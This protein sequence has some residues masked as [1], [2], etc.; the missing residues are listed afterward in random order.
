MLNSSSLNVIQ[1][2]DNTPHATHE[3]T[4]KKT[5]KALERKPLTKNRNRDTMPTPLDQ[6]GFNCLLK[7]CNACHY[8]L[9]K[10]DYFG[11]H[12]AK[13][14]T[15]E[16]SR[17]KT[18]VKA[19]IFIVN[20]SD[21]D[22]FWVGW[23]K[24]PIQ[25]LLERGW[26]PNSNPPNAEVEPEKIGEAVL[27]MPDH[28]WLL[29]NFE[30]AGHYGYGGIAE[31]LCC[32]PGC[33]KECDLRV[34]SHCH[35]SRYCSVEHQGLHWRLHK[36]AAA[37]DDD[38]DGDDDAEESVI[39]IS[40]PVKPAQTLDISIPVRE[41]ME[42]LQQE[43][44]QQQRQRQHQLQH[45]HP[46][47][48]KEGIQPPN[49]RLVEPEDQELATKFSYAVLH[50]FGSCSFAETDRQGK[51]K[52]LE[53]G[54]AG[55][56][57]LHCHGAD[58]KGGRFFPSTIKTMAD[59][60]KTLISIQ[61]H[62]FKCEKCPESTKAE[63][64]LLH[65]SHETERK[66]QKY[67][68]QKAFFLRIW[69]RL[70]GDASNSR[71]LCGPNTARFGLPKIPSIDTSQIPQKKFFPSTGTLQTNTSIPKNGVHI[72]KNGVPQKMFLPAMFGPLQVP[73]NGTSQTNIPNNGVRQKKLLPAMLGPPKVP[74]NG[75]SQT[76]GPKNDVPQ[77]K[78]LPASLPAR[79]G[80]LMMPNNG[81]S[82]TNGPKNGVPQNTLLP[83]RFGPPKI[84]QTNGPK[85]GV[86]QNKFLP[87]R[88][89]PPTMPNN[90][91]LQTNG[92]KNG[93]PQNTFNKFLPLIPNKSSICS[94]PYPRSIAFP[95]NT[96]LPAKLP[97]NGMPNIPQNTFIPLMPNKGSIS[98][99]S[100][101]KDC[102]SSKDPPSNGILQNR[103][104][105]KK[106]SSGIPSNGMPQNRV[107]P[108]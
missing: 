101:I 94:I 17:C 79:L 105:V 39:D 72:P 31:G 19:G 43:K 90:D 99:I 82:Q 73:N 11:N 60:K 27:T 8:R 107:G 14:E 100:S 12:W 22:L 7:T 49:V 32:M 108:A 95:Q 103:L 44:R 58:R 10:E 78:L 4:N 74:N 5:N 62:L 68:S 89:G 16:F 84:T 41:Q 18:C 64:L 66:R 47:P 59:T 1:A 9:P 93:V 86:P 53:I 57:C 33:V 96:F 75:T 87:A 80:P 42:H 56:E 45:Q 67:G 23:P 85:N 29:E 61:N 65:Q 36:E 35:K 51:R 70:H 20:E 69:C 25:M 91:T 40:S 6:S 50:E 24:C 38:D 98:S 106:P 21:P 55:L 83:E 104:P 92:P 48:H 13:S 71:K 52:G 37:D 81:M 15:D 88:L 3:N 28:K 63:I 97:N 77:N 34:C 2:G 76:N 102:P 54:F 46:L 26:Y 30:I